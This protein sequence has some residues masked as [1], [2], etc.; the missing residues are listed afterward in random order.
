MSSLRFARFFGS[1]AHALYPG[2]PHAGQTHRGQAST[3]LLVPPRLPLRPLP[4]AP[5]E[6]RPVLCPVPHRSSPGRSDLAGAS[7][8]PR[9]GWHPM[10]WSHQ[11]IPVLP[12][13]SLWWRDTLGSRPLT[14]RPARATRCVGARHMPTRDH[15]RKHNTRAYSPQIIT[16]VSIRMKI[17]RAL[18]KPKSYSWEGPPGPRLTSDPQAQ[19]HLEFQDR[20][21]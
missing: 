12:T 1:S 18:S 13:L 19:F 7:P 2:T 17:P 21:E 9:A 5:G 4:R 11:P 15:C 16:G 10:S 6:A 14:S 8:S 3:R 20:R